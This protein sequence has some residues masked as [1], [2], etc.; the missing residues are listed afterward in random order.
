ML[1]YGTMSCCCLSAHFG[2]KLK[3]MTN[4]A[5]SHCQDGICG[6]LLISDLVSTFVQFKMCDIK[7]R[8]AVV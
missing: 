8:R 5:E 2:I 6:A 1:T 4:K 3:Y 7:I